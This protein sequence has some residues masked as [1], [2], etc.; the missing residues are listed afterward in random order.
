MSTSV[1]TDVPV[2]ISVSASPLSK[3]GM[4]RLLRV[5]GLRLRIQ[6]E[7]GGNEKH[8]TWARLTGLPFVSLLPRLEV[9]GLVTRH[10]D[11]AP[12]C[13]DPVLMYSELNFVAFADVQCLPDRIRQGELRLLAKSRS[14]VGPRS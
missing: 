10:G 7:D 14:S 5:A 1:S 11:I 12:D 3:A 6:P 4:R 9:P 2:V 8:E 13:D